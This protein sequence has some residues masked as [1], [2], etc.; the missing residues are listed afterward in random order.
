[1]ADLDELLNSFTRVRGVNTALVVGQ[2]GLVLHS[3]AAPGVEEAESD[4][5]VLGAMASSG[6]IPAQEIGSESNRG[7]LLQGIYEYEGG[8]IVIEPIGESAIL[9]VVSTA[10][11]NL[12]LLRLQA[13]KIHPQLEEALSGL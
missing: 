3:V 6:L 2:D 9:V 1:M 7:R 5:D 13:R 12:G 10:A 11:A 8:V 4:V